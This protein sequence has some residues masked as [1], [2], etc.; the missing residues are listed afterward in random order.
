[1]YHATPF[2]STDHTIIITIKLIQESQ[3]KLFNLKNEK[4][5]KTLFVTTS[6]IFN[7]TIFINFKANYQKIV[8]IYRNS[9]LST[10]K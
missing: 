5:K 2:I 7:A 4:N 9:W 8:H 1:M 10:K 6:I 3:N